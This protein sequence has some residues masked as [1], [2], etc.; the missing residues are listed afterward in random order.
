MSAM[1]DLYKK[2][3]ADAGL[4]E[5]FERIL[6]EAGGDAGVAGKKLVEFAKEQG[7]EVTPKEISEFFKSLSEASGG[8]LSDDD[9]DSVAGGKLQSD[10]T[11]SA[12]T[13]RSI[14][15]SDCTVVLTLEEQI[16]K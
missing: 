3:A 15:K 12:G 11:V 1:K 16:W 6:A 8:P 13:V 7:Y 9:L 14:L 10:V 4:Q 2:V 5:K